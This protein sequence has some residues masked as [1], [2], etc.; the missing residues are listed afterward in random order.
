M[1]SKLKKTIS[2]IAIVVVVL[3]AVLLLSP[4]LFKGK[5]I[6]IVKQQANEMLNA[7]LEFKDF[8]LSFIR[9]FPNASLK[10]EDILLIG[11]DEFA[12]DTLFSAKEIYIS[13]NLKSLFSDS[14]YQIN[15]LIL[16]Q[17]G[18]TAHILPDGRANWDIMKASDEPEPEESDEPLDFSLQL[19]EFRINNANIVYWDEE[20]SM[21][22]EIFGL[23]HRTTGDL[24]ANSSLLK[25]NTVID[26]LNFIMDG[27]EYLSKTEI[28]LIADINA[29]LNDMIFAFSE[30]ST[31]INAIKFA[32]EGW[33]QLLDDGFD[34]DLKLNT[35]NVDFKSI[36]SMVP[37]IY[38]NSFEGLKADGAVELAGSMKGKMVGE[39]FPA[40]NFKL[41]ITDGWFQYP[42]LPKSLQNINVDVNIASKGGDLDNMT[43]D[44][45]RF[46][47]NMGGNPF[48]AK[49]HLA[50]LMSDP[51][52]NAA[53]NGKIDLGMVKDIY[54]LEE[55]MEL[56][57]VFDM[58]MN[59]AGR[60]SYYEKNQFDKF[61]FGGNMTMSNLLLKTAA[62]PQDISMP[63]T[64]MVF[65]NRYIDLN[66]RVKIGRNDIAASGKV[67][68]FVAYIFSDETVT[69]QL[70]IESNYFNL[71][72]FMSSEESAAETESLSII[73]LPNNINFTAK[74]EFKEVLYDKMQFTNAK[75]ALLLNNGVLKFQ[76]MGM[77]AFGGSMVVN[78]QYSVPQ[79]ETPKAALDLNISNVEFTQ[80]VEQVEM[81]EKIVPIFK[82]ATGNFSMTMDME[83]NLDKEMNPDLMSLNAKG[84]FSTKSV[85]LADVPVLDELAKALKRSDLSN[86]KLE[87]LKIAYTIKDGRLSTQPFDFNIGNVKIGMNGSTGLDQTINYTGNVQLPD[88]LN[89]GKLSKFD[90]KIGGTFTSP[91]VAVDVKG[92][93]NSIVDDTKEKLQ[94]EVDK[95]KEKLNEELAKQKEA[96][97][98]AAEAQGEKLKSEAK[99]AGDALVA[100]AEKQGQALVD[101]A[102][103]ALTKKAAQVSAD[104]LVEEAKK[105][106]A[107]LNKTAEEESQKL[108]DKAKET[109]K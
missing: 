69:G 7:E 75:G 94:G 37:A 44:V 4:V 50:Y 24:S 13:I 40:F 72:D 82:K 67:E 61:T 46:S 27:I 74:A 23:N 29:N 28:E 93:I 100:E 80:I 109:V 25:T 17:P 49:A 9:D 33:V 8:S 60:M 89:L 41:G 91:K 56:N 90:V 105:K 26:R 70:N 47:F 66:T 77:N 57:G 73:E 30:N 104:K 65:N 96:A 99:K 32:F 12:Q 87:N 101:K 31:R 108:I 64:T 52:V 1:N 97:I 5:I 14:G 106:A 34:M 83:T 71:N 16:N 10:L 54:P 18:I 107:Q 88:Q 19:K 36:L 42:D 38:S 20:G 85:G 43:V 76:Q 79:P 92:T 45:S 98:K 68:N 81:F 58:N 62:M 39:D 63:L 84:T 22:A 55:G 103:N 48:S 86:S 11:I 78:G 21:K 6:K 102:S 59:V 35:Q 3:F 2:A 53:A 15:K 95:A 51:L